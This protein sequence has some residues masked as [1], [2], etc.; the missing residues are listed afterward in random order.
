MSI[1][2]KKEYDAEKKNFI[3]ACANGNIPNIS[4]IETLRTYGGEYAANDFDLDVLEV[5]IKTKHFK[6]KMSK[7]KAT[8]ILA[9][10]RCDTSS[11]K[12]E[13][14]Q[15]SL[16]AMSDYINSCAV[17][18][19]HKRTVTTICFLLIALIVAGALAGLW[20]ADKSGLLYGQGI[21]SFTAD[22]QTYSQYALKYNDYVSLDLP[23]KNGYDIVGV[24]DVISGEMLFDSEGISSTKV[25]N[26]DLSDYSNSRLE[27]VYRPHVYLASVISASGMASTI[28]YTV[29]D[30]P[31]DILEEPQNLKGYGF[32]GWYTD[33]K[34]NKPFSG[35]FADY[36]DESLVL[37]PH[38]SLDGWTITWDLCGGEMLGDK[39]EQYTIL[40]DVP[41]PNSDVVKKHGYDF[42]GWSYKGQIV[43]HFPTVTM[44]DIALVAVWS[45]HVFTVKYEACCGEVDSIVD[46]FTI[47]SSLML[48]VPT[49]FGYQFEGW[50]LSKSYQT[51]IETID[52]GTVGDITVYAKWT[53]V[54]YHIEYELAGGQ[55]SVLNPDTYTVEHD[56]CLSEPSKKGYT[57]EGWFDD[58]YSIC[59]SELSA[60]KDGNI[61][62]IAKWS[63]NQYTI[64]VCP[65]NGAPIDRQ[66]VTYDSYYSVVVPQCQ[67]HDFNGLTLNG[68]K[69]DS[70][71][72]YTYDCDV[73]V[74]AH[75]VAKE[76]QIIYI[77][78]DRTIHVQSV[79]YDKPYTLYTPG[80]RENYEFTGW[81]DDC[82]CGNRVSDG[83]F[84]QE[85][86]IVVYAKWLKTLTI[87]LESGREYTVDKTVEKVYVT[88][89]HKQESIDIMQDIC[90]TVS[91]RDVDLTMCLVDVGFKGKN[92]CAAIKCENSSYLLTVLLSGN[93]FI[94][95][96]NGSD[97]TNGE[98]GSKMTE[99]NRN[100]SNGQNGG[101]A[102]D[103][104][105]VI[106]ENLTPNSSLTL[107]GGSG[108]RGGDGGV[109]KDRSRMWLN[110]V[111]NGGNGG[112]S[113]PAL[114][115]VSYSA[116]GTTVNLQTGTAGKAGNAGSRGDWW[117]SACY[118]SDGKDGKVAE[119][120]NYK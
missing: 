120:V 42:V 35:N 113:A 25:E 60:D 26:R 51:R 54:I 110:Y 63:A 46:E 57:F 58:K 94:E 95:G 34:Y 111:P 117:C 36:T 10:L 21:V 48:Q 104:G 102:L 1:F 12:S 11:P 27:V 38:Y 82:L 107:K 62:L 86:D 32:D 61:R 52:V 93:S 79:T 13:Y 47:E 6:K 84:L 80:L 28:N 31:E 78:E 59:K 71:G 119:A 81:F 5:D 103:C 37:Y 99:S 16:R 24:R 56:V 65:D 91:K 98:S 83:I 14:A 85:H 77:S 22:G 101:C 92:N 72:I 18:T 33:A 67:G 90:I 9:E 39:L 55:N 20:Y 45:P 44:E 105:T 100:G 2:S 97:G 68:E 49:R 70:V 23:Q 76:Y 17:R 115:C 29:E 8:K 19:K 30:S 88:G 64:T 66:T 73:F 53:P 114:S 118:G 112:D 41:L 108:G 75:Y 116:N 96:G 109:D 106:F 50:F 69:F 43:D 89:N 74:I 7:K 4:Q 3:L 87:N 40:T 15:T